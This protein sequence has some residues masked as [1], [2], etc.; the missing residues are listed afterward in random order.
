MPRVTEQGEA[1]GI[2]YTVKRR[3]TLEANRAML[4]YSTIVDAMGK[5]SLE[6]PFYVPDIWVYIH[7]LFDLEAVKGLVT[8]DDEKFRLPAVSAAMPDHFAAMSHVLS[9]DTATRTAIDAH[10][11]KLNEPEA[12]RH[13]LPP[14]DLTSAEQADPDFLADGSTTSSD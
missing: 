10:I 6:Y 13:I 5:T 2:T 9:M 7:F 11:V 4:F 1:G 8:A 14:G 3:T 12:P